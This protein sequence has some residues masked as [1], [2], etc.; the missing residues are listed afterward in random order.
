M[1]RAP[2]CDPTWVG[3]VSVHIVASNIAVAALTGRRPILNA[4]YDAA[5]TSKFGL[6]AAESLSAALSGPCPRPPRFPNIN[7]AVNVIVLRRF[8]TLDARFGLTDGVVCIHEWRG[9]EC[10][11]ARPLALTG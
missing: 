8:L 6:H 1:S 3:R 7:L 4:L 11:E 10:R 5:E 2:C 9:T